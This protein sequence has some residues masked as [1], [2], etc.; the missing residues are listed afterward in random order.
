MIGSAIKTSINVKDQSQNM[1]NFYFPKGTW[2]SLF[3]PSIGECL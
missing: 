2:C 3:A 1:T